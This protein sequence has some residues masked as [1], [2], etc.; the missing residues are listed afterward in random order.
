MNDNTTSS[1]AE[2]SVPDRGHACINGQFVSLQQACIPLL[3]WGFNKSDAVYDGIPFAEG[4]LFR[5]D[6]HLDRFFESMRKWRLPSPLSRHQIS[7]ICHDLIA[8]SGLR[9]GILYICTT[10]GMP[11]SPEIRDPS[12]FQSRFYAWS[13]E[14][15]QL[16]TPEQLEDGLTMIISK[17]P[18]IPENS[19]D[20][21]AKNFH[22]GDL[23]QARLEAGDRGAQNAILLG[24]DGNVAEGVG[25]NVFALIDGTLQTPGHDCLHGITR[26]TVLEIAADLDIPNRVT[27][28]PGDELAR[29][30]E[31][32]ITSSAG[33]IF[34]LTT[35]EDKPVGKRTI[36]PITQQIKD[37][38]W[39]RRTSPAYSTAVDYSQLKYTP[40]KSGEDQ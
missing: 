18:R 15:P 16:G 10:R 38:Y 5:L 7:D 14:L 22:W 24:Y 2:F 1:Q 17:V 39:K 25:F 9:D 28:I 29:A 21:T 4:R 20:S 40:H 34:A 19:V 31:I 13:Q 37:E 12:R 36:G 3:D 35:L 26:R 33:G 11:P 23:I 32:F 27:A 30:D 6:D 8:I